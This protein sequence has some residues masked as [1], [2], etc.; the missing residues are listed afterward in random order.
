MTKA[1]N[2]ELRVGVDVGAGRHSVVNRA[3]ISG[4]SKS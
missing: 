4:G 3:G 2:L 1:A